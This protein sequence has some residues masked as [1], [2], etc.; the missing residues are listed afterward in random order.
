MFHCNRL[1]FVADVCV[2]A[3]R[4]REAIAYLESLGYVIM[5]PDGSDVGEAV[6]KTK[7]LIS[8]KAAAIPVR[9]T[10]H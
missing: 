1:V 6:E 3:V 5:T 2:V 10:W 9:E 4:S 8:E 7:A